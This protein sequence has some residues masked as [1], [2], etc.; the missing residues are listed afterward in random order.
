MIII[1][2]NIIVFLIDVFITHITLVGWGSR[3]VRVD[4]RHWGRGTGL[5]GTFN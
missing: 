2:N 5:A 4:R 3:K 1:D